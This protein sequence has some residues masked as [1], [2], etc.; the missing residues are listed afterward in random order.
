MIASRKPI[1]VSARTSLMGSISWTST[2]RGPSRIRGSSDASTRRLCLV[3]AGAH[4]LEQVVSARA[5]RW[6]PLVA[7]SPRGPASVRRGARDLPF[8]EGI[9][10]R[11]SAARSGRAV[12]RLSS[13][14]ARQ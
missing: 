13:D 2:R 1:P 7:W 8:V 10:A 14:G 4:S 12:I 5:E 9:S 11:S 6:A 3:H